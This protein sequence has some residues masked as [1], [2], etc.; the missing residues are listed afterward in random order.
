M[1]MKHEDVIDDMKS[2]RLLK[3]INPQWMIKYHICYII[4]QLQLFK[5]VFIGIDKAISHLY[6]GKIRHPK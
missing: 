4:I 1:L 2:S 6:F 3:H 5:Y